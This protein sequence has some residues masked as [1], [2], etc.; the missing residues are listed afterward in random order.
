MGETVKW[1]SLMNRRNHREAVIERG[2]GKIENK[3]EKE[4]TEI[5]NRRD[6]KMPNH[7]KRAKK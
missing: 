2:E 6:A 5:Y 7:N 3:K 4:K 1:E